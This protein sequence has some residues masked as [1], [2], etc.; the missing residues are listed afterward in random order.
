VGDFNGDGRDDLAVVQNFT[1]QVSIFLNNSPQPADGVTVYRDIV[2]YD[3]PYANP[4]REDLDVY[5]PP[6]A[7]NFPV[8][9][10]VFGGGMRNGDK[11]RFGYLAQALAREGLGVV[12]INYRITDGSPQQVVFPAHEVDVARAFAWTYQHI[13]DYGG[14]PNNIFVMGHSSGA[15][16]V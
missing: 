12:A 14:D 13:A 7:T 5:V 3:G 16:L 8:V 6:E 11:A 4:Q 15:Q 1:N 2:Y 10:L 9:F